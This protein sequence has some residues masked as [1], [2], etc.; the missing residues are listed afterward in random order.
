MVTIDGWKVELINGRY[1]LTA[2]AFSDHP[3]LG[4][5]GHDDEG[6]LTTSPLEVLDLARGYAVT[7]SGT[8][9]LLAE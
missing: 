3:R 7:R 8:H 9:Y 4:S 6:R 2:D 1:H 5:S